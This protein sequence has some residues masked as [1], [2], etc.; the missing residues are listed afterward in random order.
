MKKC[1]ECGQI[2]DDSSIFCQNC[3]N[4]LEVVEEGPTV[5]NRHINNIPVNGNYHEK[6]QTMKMFGYAAILLEIIV[7]LGAW[8]FVRLINS[9]RMMLYPLLCVLVSFYCAFKLVDYEETIKDSKIIIAASIILFIL[10]LIL[11]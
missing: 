11:V 9:D 5:E 8:A 2:A 10:G 1:P 7:I 6:I 4:T 3:G